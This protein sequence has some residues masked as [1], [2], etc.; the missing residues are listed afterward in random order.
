[1][2]RF[3][4]PG[5]ILDLI[6]LTRN[7]WEEAGVLLL[8]SIIVFMFVEIFCWGK[9]RQPDAR[10]L[11]NVTQNSLRDFRA[12]A[13][14]SQ[15]RHVDEESISFI[16][17]GRSRVRGSIASVLDMM[18]LTLAV[19]PSPSQIRG[20]VPILTE[21]L[22][23]LTATERAARAHPDAPPHIP[24]LSFTD[25]AVDMAGILYAPELIAPPPIIWLP[26]DAAGIARSEAA[27]LQ[28]YHALQVTL[29]VTTKEDILPRRFSPF[30]KRR[31]LL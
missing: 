28:Q 27:D 15:R 31:T 29:D 18:S 8:T 22:D 6:F 5:L 19:V 10:S 1:M 21:T 20:P 16:S 14:P 24:P 23:D 25:H 3:T 11:S 7:L 2:I 26:N 9:T 13:R 30:R 17:S 12:T 4:Y